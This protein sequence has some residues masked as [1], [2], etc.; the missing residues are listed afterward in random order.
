MKCPGDYFPIYFPK[1]EERARA[2]A[3]SIGQIKEG[4]VLGNLLLSFN[5][6]GAEGTG[7]LNLSLGGI[8]S[9]AFQTTTSTTSIW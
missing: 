4:G 6:S 8:D 1:S 3:A 5:R 9:S 2:A 7:S